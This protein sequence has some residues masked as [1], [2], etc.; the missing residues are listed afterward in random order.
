MPRST[1]GRLGFV[2]AFLKRPGLRNLAALTVIQ[3]SNALVPLL[4]LPVALS[5]IGTGAYAQVAIA[6]AVSTLALAAVIYSFDID[7]V[8]RLAQGPAH[9]RG[10]QGEVFSQV[11]ITRLLIFL[12]TAPL[13]LV[14]FVLAGGTGALLLVLWLLVPLGYIFHSYWF[15]QASEANVPAAAFTILP[16]VATLAI[17][18]ALVDD[19]QDAALIP[20]A[21]GGPFVVSGILSTCYIVLVRGIPLRPV[22]RAEITSGLKRGKEVFAGN[23]GVSLYREMNVLVLGIVGAPPAGIS[24]YALVEKSVK[25]LQA[26]ARPLNQLYFP[27]ILRCLTGSGGPDRE[28]ARLIGRYTFPQLGVALALIL[29]A[30]LAYVTAVEMVPRL[31]PL[32][33]LPDLGPMAVIMAPAMLFGIGNFMFGTAGLNALGQRGYLFLAIVAT[34]VVSIAMSLAF[35][36]TLGAIGASLCFVFAEAMLFCLI[37]LRYLR[38][39]PDGGPPIAPDNRI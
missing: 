36:L 16:R 1:D 37:I 33:E 19:S 7:A 6:E 29:A 21:I 39:T 3:G 30:F 17:V 4:I 13:L 5:T 2:R 8:A 22:T 35:S 27:K 20:L 11:L 18:F 31:R 32:S 38:A 24:T 34:G 28:A 26:A 10:F 9:D 23:V 25:M 15:Y 14:L 12:I